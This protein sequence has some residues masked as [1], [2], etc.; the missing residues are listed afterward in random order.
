MRS[1][2]ALGV[3]LCLL[4]SAAPAHATA[5]GDAKRLLALERASD[6]SLQGV[7]EPRSTEVL[8][9][10]EACI[11]EDLP[12]TDESAG[13]A[14]NL[15]LLATFEP[16]ISHFDRHAGRLAS[17]RTG[18]RVVRRTA[19]AMGRLYRALA[20]M[21]TQVPDPCAYFDAWRT[22]GWSADFR[23][24]GGPP[25]LTATEKADFLR[26]IR[27]VV[28]SAPLF[29]FFGVPDRPI[30]NFVGGYRAM[31]IFTQLPTL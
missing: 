1:L 2:L 4:L 21:P 6:Q 8:A 3:L 7:I 9:R 26:D 18:N 30:R 20:K 11:P 22:A 5:R 31:R 25:A 19:R 14:G 12:K 29:R 27:T 17:F 28:R 10:L 24:E 16:A 15:S 23:F 13:R